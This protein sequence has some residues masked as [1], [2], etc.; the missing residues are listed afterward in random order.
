MVGSPAPR[1]SGQQINLARSPVLDAR[2]LAFQLTDV[3]ADLHNLVVG[4]FARQKQRLAMASSKSVIAA[5]YHAGP[6][7]RSG[8]R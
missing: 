6:A 7:A 3:I 8:G 2:P 4:V 5:V 1:H